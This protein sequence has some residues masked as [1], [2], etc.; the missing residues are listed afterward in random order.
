MR[1]SLPSIPCSYKEIYE[2][3]TSAKYHSLE[4][5]YMDYDTITE[6]DKMVT[7]DEDAGLEYYQALLLISPAHL[8]ANFATITAIISLIM[9]AATIVPDTIDA[10]DASTTVKAETAIP[11]NT[12]DTPEWG[13]NVSPR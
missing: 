4:R 5:I 1:E 6:M 9:A 12:K 10:R 2:I 7:E 8:K 11:V 13:N 3:K